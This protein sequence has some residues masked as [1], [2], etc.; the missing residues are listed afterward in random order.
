MKKYHRVFFRITPEL[1]ENL[2]KFITYYARDAIVEIANMNLDEIKKV[3]IEIADK[4]YRNT[5]TDVAVYVS[6]EIYDKWRSI[7][8][9]LK[10]QAQYLISQKLLKIA[11]RSKN[12]KEAKVSKK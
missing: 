2:G 9:H 4:Y 3:P 1:R 10:K 8:W 11:K 12:K 6:K 5:T 7:P